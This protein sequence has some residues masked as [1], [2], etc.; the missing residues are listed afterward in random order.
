MQAKLLKLESLTPT[1]YLVQ[2][3]LPE[4]L[5][6]Q[7]G[8]YLQVVM[9]ERD[10]RPFSIASAP[11]AN[12]SEQLD[13]HIGATPDNRYAWD[14]ITQLRE[15]G[16][17]TIEAPLGAAFYRADEQRPIILVAG[18]TGFS[19]TWSILQAHLA[20]GCKTPL[21]L[22]WGGRVRADLYYHEQLQALAKQYQN[23]H[24]RPVVEEAEANWQG[25]LGL[26]HHAVMAE[27]DDLAAAHVYVA[28]R[29]EMVRVV[30][31]D[32]HARGLPL[33][34]LFGDALAFI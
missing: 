5:Q 34:Q 31:D 1:V 11:Q 2:L 7:A 15:Q 26:V 33:S 20:N 29:F 25:A 13:L 30:R 19:Y 4:P 22:Y 18:G 24:Y 27:Q 14:V 32:F 17:M 12:G 9:G 23:F 16:E 6:F 8:Q 21:T 28:G 10:K 3:Q